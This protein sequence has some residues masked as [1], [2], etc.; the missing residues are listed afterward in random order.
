MASRRMPNKRRLKN[1]YA[2]NTV[3]TQ[4]DTH[5]EKID[6]RHPSLILVNLKLPGLMLEIEAE[7]SKQEVRIAL[8][9]LK[10]LC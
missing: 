4:V 2:P 1:A 10:S 6:D 8:A 7:V 3:E 5:D 9:V